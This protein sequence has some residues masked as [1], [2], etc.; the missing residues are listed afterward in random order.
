MKSFKFS[1]ATILAC[2]SLVSASA[3][4]TLPA[5]WVLDSEKVFASSPALAAAKSIWPERWTKAGDIVY[6]IENNTGQLGLA[7]VDGGS[8]ALLD[9]LTFPK[10]PEG[11]IEFRTSSAVMPDGRI[12]VLSV[13]YRLEK[14]T[15]TNAQVQFR[16]IDPSTK[17]LKLAFHRPMAFDNPASSGE[18]GVVSWTAQGC[19]Q[20]N[21]FENRA[22]VLNPYFL[23]EFDAA[24]WK[25][26]HGTRKK[27]GSLNQFFT[28]SGVIWDVSN[29][30][31]FMAKYGGDIR[32]IPK[33]E[34]KATLRS[35]NI[36]FDGW[37]ESAPGLASC[38]NGTV[39]IS[40]RRLAIE[41]P[42]PAN[43]AFAYPGPNG[44]CAVVVRSP[45]EKQVH[46]GIRLPEK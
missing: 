14:E 8:G 29:K 44:L 17:K 12:V 37:M 40:R 31:Y 38:V 3:E 32:Q 9:T 1:L 13:T 30:D 23:I 7:L 15:K 46:C 11:V 35:E 26:L 21:H 20:F 24:T 39:E 16:V 34:A 2:V 33:D 28:K 6:S 4:E 10:R 27:G 43:A 19:V 36:P 42:A 45:G 5:A 22:A 25:P 41:L 18:S